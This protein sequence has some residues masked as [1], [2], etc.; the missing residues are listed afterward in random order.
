[1]DYDDDG[2]LDFVSGSYDPGDLYLFRGEGDGKYAAVEK[3]VDQDGLALVHHPK[4]FAEWSNL[5]ESEQASG[6]MDTIMLRVASF[7]SW[8]ATVDWDADGDLDMLI[9]SFGGDLFLRQNI[10]TRSQPEYDA[11]ASLCMSIIMRLPR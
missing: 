6:E 10:G 7:G 1:M 8:P 11:T 9:G 5:E 3:I 4:E 2:I